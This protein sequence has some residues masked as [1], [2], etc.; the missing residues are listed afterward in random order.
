MIQPIT[1]APRD[2]NVE[3]LVYHR[4]HGWLTARWA[5][6]YWQDHQ[7]GREYNGPVWIIGD[8]LA[9]EEVEEYPPGEYH[10]GSITHWMPLPE[11]PNV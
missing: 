3:I 1:T 7:E 9:Q 5:A 4:V 2:E 10:D 8:D 6:G 11:K